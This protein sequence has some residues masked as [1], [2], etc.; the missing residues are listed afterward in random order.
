MEDKNSCHN[1]PS[2]WSLLL[3]KCIFSFLFMPLITLSYF[4]TLSFVLLCPS[5]KINNKMIKYKNEIFEVLNLNRGLMSSRD[6]SDLLR[7]HIVCGCPHVNLLINI[8][9]RDNEEHS[10]APSSSLHLEVNRNIFYDKI[11]T[12]AWMSRPSLKMTARS[13][14][15]VTILLLH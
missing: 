2:K 5:F 1:N 4:K 13:Y 15:W 9:T 8:K 7:G 6:Y 14:S 3:L 11:L 10:G 12:L